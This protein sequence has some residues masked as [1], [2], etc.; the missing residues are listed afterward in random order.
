MISILLTVVLAVISFSVI[1]SEA[2]INNIPRNNSENNSFHHISSCIPYGINQSLFENGGYCKS[3]I[4]NVLVKGTILELWDKEKK[5]KRFDS[6]VRESK[7][8]NLTAVRQS[9]LKQIDDIYCHHYFQRCYIDFTVQRVCREACEKL[10]SEHCEPEF[11]KADHLNRDGTHTFHIID[12]TDLPSRKGTG[13]CYEPANR[14]EEEL[15]V[16]NKDCF[17][18][19]GRGYRG[20][21]ST[22][23]SGYTC[24]PWSAPHPHLDQVVKQQIS[25][26]IKN[27]SNSCRNPRGLSVKSPWCLISNRTVQWEYCDVPKCSIDAPL[28][29]PANFRGHSLNSTSIELSW[30]QVPKYLRYGTVLGFHL[31][32]L[33]LHSTE[34]HSVNLPSAQLNWMFKGLRKF[35]SYSCRLR[36]YDRF[37]NGTWSEKLVITDEDVPDRPPREISALSLGK[38]AVQLNWRPV[39][40]EHTNGM[41]LGYRVFYNEVHNTSRAASIK[42]AAEE[43]HLTIGGLRPSTNYSFQILAFTTKGNGTISAK[44]FAKTFSDLSMKRNRESDDRR[45]SSTTGLGTEGIVITVVI[46]SIVAVGVICLA[47]YFVRKKQSWNLRVRYMTPNVPGT[48]VNE[49]LVAVEATDV[50][51]VRELTPLGEIKTE[52]WRHSTERLTT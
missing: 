37:G 27:G 20:S 36:A 31:A 49:S 17:I 26:E 1:S 9:C 16:S 39:S 10:K 15:N 29:P 32:C 46:S 12:C 41:V 21:I 13:I 40:P 30:G 50:G 19:D 11:E 34:E 43:T 22:T 48:D 42:V 51:E 45:Q 28:N 6:F 38:N 2:G 24:Q 23:I 47:I 7:Q 5:L 18:G 25:E 52:G 8:Q 33:R 14:T 3:I 4:G 35:T 44:Y